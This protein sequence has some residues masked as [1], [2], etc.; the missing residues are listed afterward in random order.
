M[1]EALEVQL[2]QAAADYVPHI[3]LSY[4]GYFTALN[5][6][7]VTA[8]GYLADNATYSVISYVPVA[9]LPLALATAGTS[10]VTCACVRAEYCRRGMRAPPP[11]LTLQST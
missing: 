2:G 5:T 1:I 11:A 4:G 10:C 7:A 9:S 6:S 3:L 8:P